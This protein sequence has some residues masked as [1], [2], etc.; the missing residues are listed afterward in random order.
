MSTPNPKLVADVKLNLETATAVSA[1]STT[2]SNSN[3]SSQALLDA[4]LALNM[5]KDKKSDPESVILH[6][7]GEPR[8]ISIENAKRWLSLDATGTK[9]TKENLAGGSAV[10]HLGDVYF[11]FCPSYVESPRLYLTEQAV[12][13]MSLL[14][15]GDIIAP[16]RFLVFEFPPDANGIVKKYM[17]Q[18][19]LAIKGLDLEDLLGLPGTVKSLQNALGD[20]KFKQDFEALLKH[21]YYAEWLSKKGVNPTLDW[22]KQC[23]LLANELYLLSLQDRPKEFQDGSLTKDQIHRMILGNREL[24]GAKSRSDRSEVGIILPILALLSKYPKVSTWCLG[25]LLAVYRRLELLKQLYPDSTPT[26]I[27]NDLPT[28]LSRFNPENISKHFLLALLT[29]PQDHHQGGNFKVRVHRGQ[30]KK[31]FSLEIIGIDNDR[32][33][34]GAIQVTKRIDSNEFQYKV[35]TKTLFYGVT[36]FLERDCFKSVAENICK[37]TPETIIGQWLTTM[38]SYAEP[39]LGLG[40]YHGNKEQEL[41]KHLYADFPKFMI[42]RLAKLQSLLKEPRKHRIL[43]LELEPLLGRYCEELLKLR[44]GDP[45]RFAYALREESL[46]AL[47]K[48]LELRKQSSDIDKKIINEEFEKLPVTEFVYTSYRESLDRFVKESLPKGSTAIHFASIYCPHTIKYLVQEGIRLDTKNDLG[49]TALDIA[50]ERRV[51]E[52]IKALLSFGAGRFVSLKNGR[53]FIDSFDDHP[54]I[55]QSL[56]SQ[57]ADLSWSLALERISD[58]KANEENVILEGLKGRRYLKPEI[59]QQVFELKHGKYIFRKHNIF[60]RHNVVA[61]NSEVHSGVTVG[62]HLKEKPELFV[63]ELMVHHL[64]KPLF[65]MITPQIAA[66]RFI[67]QNGASRDEPTAFPIMASRS[68]EGNTLREALDHHPHQLALLDKQSFFEALILALLIN[69]ED[70]RADQYILQPFQQGNETRYRLVSID[71]EYAFVRPLAKNSKGEEI[72]GPLGVQVKTI[73]FCLNEMQESLPKNVQERLMQ[74][75][76]EIIL[77]K[78][79]KDLAVQQKKIDAIFKADEKKKLQDK[80][81]IYLNIMLKSRLVIEIRDKLIVMKRILS[82][83]PECSGLMLLRQIHP[84]LSIRYIDAFYQ[85]NTADERFNAISKGCFDKKFIQHS[86]HDLYMRPESKISLLVPTGIKG[87]AIVVFQDKWECV[88][89]YFVKNGQWVTQGSPAKLVRILLGMNLLPK[90]IRHQDGLVIKHNNNAKQIEEIIRLAISLLKYKKEC[91]MSMT[92]SASIMKMTNETTLKE[93]QDKMPVE[94]IEELGKYVNIEIERKELQK[95][96]AQSL[97]KFPSYSLITREEIVNGRKQA[98]G[99]DFGLMKCSDGKPDIKLQLELLNIFSQTEFSALRIRNCAMLTDGNLMNVLK[100]SKGLLILSLQGCEKITDEVFKNLVRAC[101]NLEKLELNGLKIVQV[102]ESFS[103]LKVLKIKNCQ[104]IKSWERESVGHFEFEVINCPLIT[105]VEFYQKYPFLLSLSPLISPISTEFSTPLLLAID[106]IIKVCLYERKISLELLPIEVKKKLKMLLSNYC[107]IMSQINLVDWNLDESELVKMEHSEDLDIYSRQMNVVRKEAFETLSALDFK[108][109]S[110]KIESLLTFIRDTTIA[111]SVRKAAAEILSNLAVSLETALLEPV[112]K[113]L[114]AAIQ[115]SDR[116]A[117]ACAS[118]I[119]GNIGSLDRYSVW[120]SIEALLSVIE[121][122]SWLTRCSMAETLHDLYLELSQEFLDPLLV[123]QNNIMKKNGHL[124]TKFMKEY[125]SNVPFS[126]RRDALYLSFSSIEILKAQSEAMKYN[127]KF[128]REAAADALGKLA[129]TMGTASLGSVIRRLIEAIHESKDFDSQKNI[130]EAVI[131]A[132]ATL[133]SGLN[134]EWLNLIVRELF[135]AVRND[136]WEIGEVATKAIKNLGSNIRPELLRQLLILLLNYTDDHHELVRKAAI[137][138]IDRLSSRLSSELLEPAVERLIMV[139][140]D[141]NV[142]ETVIEVLGNLRTKLNTKMLW[143]VLDVLLTVIKSNC[144]NFEN[145]EMPDWCVRKAAAKALVNIA[146]D[147][148]E[149]LQAVLKGLL[150]ALLSAMKDK[151]WAAKSSIE[152]DLMNL[153]AKVSPKR[154]ETMLKVLLEETNE[155]LRFQNIIIANFLLLVTGRKYFYHVIYVNI[156]GLFSEISAPSASTSIM[157]LKNSSNMQLIPKASK[158]YAGSDECSTSKE[159]NDATNAQGVMNAFTLGIIELTSDKIVDFS[160]NNKMVKKINDVLGAKFLD[161]EGLLASL[162]K[163]PDKT[164]QLAVLTPMLR[165]LAI[166]YIESHYSYYQ[167]SFKSDLQSAYKEFKTEKYDDTF[168]SHPHILKKFN[169]LLHKK[170]DLD[171]RGTKQRKEDIELNVWW[172]TN[173]RGNGPRKEYFDNLKQAAQNSGEVKYWSTKIDS[174]AIQAL[175]F[176]FGI[177]VK[178]IEEANSQLWGIGNGF[179]TGL[180]EPEILH[181]T[182]LKIGSRFNDGF[183]IEV[184]RTTLMRQLNLETLSENER[185]FLDE[186]GKKTILIFM[187][188]PTTIPETDRKRMKEL[189]EKLERIG[190]L[191]RSSNKQLHFVELEEFNSILKPVPTALKKRVIA[192]YIEPPTFSIKKEGAN[193]LCTRIDS[194]PESIKSTLAKGTVEGQEQRKSLFLFFQAHN[195]KFNLKLC[196]LITEYACDSSN[197][198]SL[199][200]N[201]LTAVAIGSP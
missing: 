121:S 43:L 163:E 28:L 89:A 178:N 153:V 32:A 155:N 198:R 130:R 183:R 11:K 135:K 143:L 105:Q 3:L 74:I 110:E 95:G 55:C 134:L 170:S 71:N 57:N 91:S 106:N 108:S 184:N 113:T 101:P 116:N 46:P 34:Q 49:K 172:D 68:I 114:F 193:W 191:L 26:E 30:T 67:C 160:K 98:F 103:S 33:Q 117:I 35:L 111:W 56:L 190:L 62:L 88:D 97:R 4:I 152:K 146:L 176:Y 158:A 36:E 21:D 197:E 99:I 45:I 179:V 161:K 58:E 92:T 194:L 182:H 181:L 138:A 125:F 112:L 54:E 87:N 19:S 86:F 159:L 94:V 64:A 76:P 165:V 187:G 23:L 123:M 40:L 59:Y 53:V 131:R 65:G 192:E 78:W 132:L 107:V 38:V 48:L 118:E 51:I 124:L 142:R 52:G 5:L 102:Q 29:N 42:K 126:N 185:S 195:S 41:H 120:T 127:V 7:L 66:M 75:D 61:I 12:Y 100:C 83:H 115:S 73:L 80:K 133:G 81:N 169:G 122:H 39:Y 25:D 147:H 15:G 157:N 168:C 149:I 151:E 141:P 70:G 148:P 24:Q 174:L 196:D 167:D 171:V 119:L 44:G 166:E 72:E 199:T 200:A 1:I 128:V 136:W 2:T 17:L 16:T 84:N 13:Q 77:K 180:T 37:Q 69:P 145:I 22:E 85:Y 175:A 50:I 96:S 144:L 137:R 109:S 186:N 60:G 14:L 31:M 177:T 79:L 129:L 139:M 201:G 8:Y 189:C 90:G 63:R 164:K 104:H 47:P 93:E 173:P 18:A 10:T 162:K 188:N 82:E 9:N 154:L 6:G 27:L 156:T 150:G 20:A 140:D